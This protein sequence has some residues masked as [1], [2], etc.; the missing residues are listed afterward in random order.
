M[1][2]EK[3]E[4]EGEE[5]EESSAAPSPSSTVSRGFHRDMRYFPFSLPLP[6]S[7]SMGF[8]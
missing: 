3:E 1:E 6:S 8:N 2:E 7:G 4:E 5:E